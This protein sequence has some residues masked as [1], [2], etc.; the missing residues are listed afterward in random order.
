MKLSV[1]KHE[2]TSIFPTVKMTV[3]RFLD[4]DCLSKN[5]L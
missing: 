5:Y 2:R 4:A 1:K 3:E